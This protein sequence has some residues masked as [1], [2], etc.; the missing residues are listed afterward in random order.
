MITITNIHIDPYRISQFHR[1]TNAEFKWIFITQGPHQFSQFHIWIRYKSIHVKT[2]TGGAT[3]V[4]NQYDR[5]QLSLKLIFC[6]LGTLI[7]CSATILIFTNISIIL[8]IVTII[9]QNNYNYI[10]I[11][12]TD[13]SSSLS[14]LPVSPTSLATSS[15]QFKLCTYPCM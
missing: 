3:P 9:K 7:T 12:I 8:P 5:C 15:S 6:L 4:M 14:S 1:W 11:A 13:I 2:H 10:F